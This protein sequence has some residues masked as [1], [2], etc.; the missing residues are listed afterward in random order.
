MPGSGPG[1][2]TVYP[3]IN[4]EGEAVFVPLSAVV[5]CVHFLL[6]GNYAELCTEKAP[7]VIM[8]LR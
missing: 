5:F 1:R 3:L 4:W 2:S 7:G 6:C 8:T